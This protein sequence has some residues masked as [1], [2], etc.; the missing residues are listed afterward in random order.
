VKVNTLIARL[1]GAGAAEP[2]AAPAPVAKRSRPA[3][4]RRASPKRPRRK[5]RSPPPRPRRSGN[6]GR[7]EMKKITVRDALRD[8]MAEEMRR[9]DASS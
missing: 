4:P 5:P 3:K 8:A 1:K 2:A 9:D 7:H 6:P